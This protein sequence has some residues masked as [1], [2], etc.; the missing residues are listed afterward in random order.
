MRSVSIWIWY[1]WFVQY[2]CRHHTRRWPYW[3][4]RPYTRSTNALW[5]T[6]D[7]LS[8]KEAPGKFNDA[9]KALLN[10]PVA[11][12]EHSRTTQLLTD[13]NQERF[14][15]SN[16]TINDVGGYIHHS[17]EYFN[18]NGRDCFADERANTLRALFMP[19]EATRNDVLKIPRP[20]QHQLSQDWKFTVNMKVL[21]GWGEKK[22][23]SHEGK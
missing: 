5:K 15:R 18:T 11:A 7:S 14:V 19:L 21:E 4:E 13:T 3:T 12:F 8:Y 6:Y 10:R 1:E 2:W 22:P 9:L 17:S 16:I 20:K 23:A